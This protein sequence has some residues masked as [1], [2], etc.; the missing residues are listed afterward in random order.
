MRWTFK[1]FLIKAMLVILSLYLS[2]NIYHNYKQSKI[3]AE[4]I[5]PTEQISSQKYIISEELI[6]G[7]LKAKSQI[8]SIEQSFNS[9]STLV[10]DNWL[11]ERETELKVK[12]NYKMGLNTNEIEVKH[13]D[14]TS[15]VV[16]IKLPD[17]VIISLQ[18]PYDDIG[19][20]KTK[21]FLRLSMNEDEEKNFYKSVEKEIRNKLN[22][23]KE[24]HKQA[25]LH[26]HEVVK[27]LLNSVGVN[28]VIFE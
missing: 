13:V 23:D 19:I 28:E 21:G 4:V 2:A 8:V 5:Q 7:K 26:N 9:K 27:G 11:G 25:V 1:K 12:G 16:Y 17:P 6:M 15:G 3:K 14:N 10:D 24:I 20:D 18:L 22:K